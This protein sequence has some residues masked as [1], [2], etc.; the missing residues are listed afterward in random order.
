M[1]T[2]KAAARR[3]KVLVIDIGGSHIKVLAP[4][5]REPIE[6]NSGPRMTPGQM[7]AAVKNAVGNR[8]YDVVSL[9][10]PGLVIDGV[11]R[12][13][14]P[15]LGKGWIRFDFA[16]A[17]HRPVK[18]INDAAMQAL[19]SY[20]GGRML[21][22][23]LGTGLGS[24]LM[25]DGVLHAT[26]LGDLPYL[27]G[28][29]CSDY[30]KKAAQRKMGK[31]RWSRHVI[32]VV[33]FFAQA[34]LPDYTVIGGGQAKLVENLPRGTEVVDNSKAFLGGKRLWQTPPPFGHLKWFKP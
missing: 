29:P 20:H 4:G 8:D 6:I 33:R 23:G 31:A 34:L 17:F 25:L 9:G 7:V 27:N 32:K 5:S 18:I 16:K 13:N 14:P 21:F 30:V 12:K 19:G 22:L 26:E 28:R 3:R 1:S 15:N 2:W 11:P 24:A 10:Y